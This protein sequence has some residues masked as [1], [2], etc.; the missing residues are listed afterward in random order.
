MPD[1]FYYALAVIIPL[2]AVII[3][4]ICYFK[5]QYPKDREMERIRRQKVEEDYKKEPEYAFTPAKVVGAR[6]YIYTKMDFAMPMLPLLVEEYYATF[7]LETGEQIEYKI[8]EELFFT[9]KEGEEGTLVT[10]NGNFFDFGNGEEIAGD[11]V[12]SLEEE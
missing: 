3:I 1:T 5:F 6:K 2:L 8:S 10:V 4:V 9:L 7:L 11:T 12:E